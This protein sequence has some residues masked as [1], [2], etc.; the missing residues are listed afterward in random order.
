MRTALNRIER[1]TG[2]F[3]V[4]A[5]LLLVAALVIGGGRSGMAG[6]VAK[7]FVLYVVAPEG[8]G[9]Q[10][11]SPI[12]LY[13]VKIGAVSKVEIIRDPA[14]PKHPV[15]MTIEIDPA[16]APMLHQ[17]AKVALEAGMPPFTVAVLKLDTHAGPPLPAN[18]TLIAERRASLVTALMSNADVISRDVHKILV[19]SEIA[20]TNIAQITKKLNDGESV[21]SR[22]LTDP[23]L[24]SDMATAF[25]DA[26]AATA[27]AKRMM[28]SVSTAAEQAPATVN[29]V[30]AL[31]SDARATTASVR[32]G[33]D[34]A[35]RVVASVE[36]TLRLVEQMAVSLRTTASYAPELAR[37]ADTSLEESKRLVEA[38]QRNIFIRGN[39]E[40]R[41][42]A[43][44]Q[45]RVRPPAVLPG[46]KPAR[47]N[48]RDSDSG[49]DDSSR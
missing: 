34:D 30:R 9:V 47:S 39:L 23:E 49:G 43:R 13:D 22:V 45:A 21:A 24:G 14:Y 28:A 12:H 16:M 41:S 3:V 15:R 36:R 7:S 46:A 1:V 25:G 38:A 27:D 2:I 31:T 17:D 26:R 35:R 11:G 32:E 5:L 29:D 33:I 40:P 20:L 48:D 44:T 10:A 37:K 6:L 4:L 19:Q 8:Y 42:P 18:T